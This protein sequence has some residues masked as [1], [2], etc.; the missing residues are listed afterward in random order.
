MPHVHKNAGAMR[1]L[2]FYDIFQTH[3]NIY[4]QKCLSLRMFDRLNQPAYGLRTVLLVH[5]LL[6]GL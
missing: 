2:S 4:V 1:F 5:S 3:T 6:M